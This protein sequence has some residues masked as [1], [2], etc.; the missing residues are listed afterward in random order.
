MNHSTQ[1]IE[2]DTKHLNEDFESSFSNNVDKKISSVS[3]YNSIASY[4][5]NDLIM[6]HLSICGYRAHIDDPH[7]M[8]DNSTTYPHVLI[9]SETWFSEQSIS[10]SQ[11]FKGHHTEN[12]WE[13]WWGLICQRV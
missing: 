2:T 12:Y 10:D 9:P 7:S 6:M 8:F 1:S 13:V 11:G 4:S 3:D 5:E